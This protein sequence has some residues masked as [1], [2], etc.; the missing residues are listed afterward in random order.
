MITA[1]L[2]SKPAPAPPRRST[3]NTTTATHAAESQEYAAREQA[4]R[5]TREDWATAAA[6]PR[7]HA[8]FDPI[9]RL[10]DDLDDYISQTLMSYNPD[11][12]YSP[13]IYT[14]AVD[15]DRDRWRARAA[16][17][18]EMALQ[19]KKGT[20][21]LQKPPP[22]ANVRLT[23]GSNSTKRGF[24]VTLSSDC[25]ALLNP[26][27]TSVPSRKFKFSAFDK[28]CALSGIS[29]SS[30]Q[31]LFLQNKGRRTI[32]LRITVATVSGSVV[33]S[34]ISINDLRSSIMARELAH[35]MSG[36][37]EEIQAK[38]KSGYQPSAVTCR[39]EGGETEVEKSMI[40]SI[41]V[42]S[43]SSVDYGEIHRVGILIVKRLPPHGGH[44]RKVVEVSAA[45]SGLKLVSR[46]Q[47]IRAFLKDGI[48]VSSNLLIVRI[49]YGNH[50][51][52]TYLSHDVSG[53]KSHGDKHHGRQFEDGFED[54][55]SQ[56]A[57][58]TQQG[59][60]DLESELKFTLNTCWRG[61]LI[62]A[63]CK[64]GWIGDPRCGLGGGGSNRD[65][66]CHPPSATQS[67]SMDFQSEP[68][69]E[70]NTGL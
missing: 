42:R 22:S 18:V 8:A 52:V 3:R 68:A 17:V 19:E 70:R 56:S 13:K 33:H 23:F 1:L 28:A 65:S 30:I 69:M 27:L 2:F 54:I 59:P 31:L 38:Y 25:V 67:K 11:L 49:F 34:N 51:A 24:P 66:Q 36:P 9:A 15:L 26:A 62:P 39:S 14:E 20:W 63:K 37:Q 16:M 29:G 35:S 60:M 47:N 45:N 4:A 58:A 43:E 55:G 7:A 46:L 57:L 10:N 64:Q 50:V 61:N 44:A 5:S 40:K 12:L 21:E 6:K 53:P 48:T 32:V 41:R